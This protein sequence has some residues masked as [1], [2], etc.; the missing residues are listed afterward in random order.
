MIVPVPSTIEEA[1]AADGVIL[2]IG[3]SDTGKSS[4]IASL[5]AQQADTGRQVMVLDLDVGQSEVGPPGMM[6]LCEAAPDKPVSEWRIRAQWYVG[7]TT[8]FPSMVEVVTGALRLAE[9]A[10][11]LGAELVLVDTPSF[12]NTPS[13]H[14][15][16]RFLV[17]AL[18]PGAV[19]AIQRRDELERWLSGIGAPVVRTEV[20]SGVRPKP[21]G[22]RAARR[23]SKLARYFADARRHQVPL[24]DKLLRGT[25][26]GFGTPLTSTDHRIA[27]PLL[28]CPVLHAERGAA[29]VAFWTLGPPR[30]SLDKV[31]A[32]F[33]VRSAVTFDCAFWA[34]R[35][36]GFIGPHGF[37]VAMGV[38]EKVDWPSL[39]AA[40]RAPVYSLAEAIAVHAGTMRHRTD[41][42]GLP[43]VPERDA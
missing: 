26:L 41:G 42:T 40:V 19:L 23:A 13:G 31:A 36:L 1:V 17:D 10:I 25:R 3:A 37:C 4:R 34:G 12:V 21:P 7:A 20:A 27:S 22:L 2:A 38:I 8:P 30:H 39:T 6:D 32:E 9:R 18:R 43:N 24:T 5:A 15:L 35:S 28:G 16:S 11:E 33:G 29:S 14:G